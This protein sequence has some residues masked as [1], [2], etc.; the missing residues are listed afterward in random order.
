VGAV[1]R[2]EPGRVSLLARKTGDAVGHLRA[3]VLPGEIGRVAFEAEDLGRIGEFQV[4]LERGAGP[5]PP[6]FDAPVPLVGVSV[7][8]GGMRRARGLRCLV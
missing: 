3:R 5:D 7:L 4:A 2:E 6:G 8:R 1:E